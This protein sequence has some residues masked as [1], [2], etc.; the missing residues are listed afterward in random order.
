MSETAGPLIVFDVETQKLF[1]EVGGPR[2]AG[3]LGLS[4]AV[5]YDVDTGAFH[6]FTEQN[7]GELI[8]QLFAARLVVGYNTL[9]FDYAVLKAYTDR[10]FNRVPSL[11]IFDHVYRRTNYRSRLDT[12]AFETLGVGKSG[13]GREAIVMWREG[14]VEELLAYCRDDV[15][16]TYELYQYGKEHG[17]VFTRDPRGRRTRVPIMW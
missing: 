11:D 15:R 5:S 16:L 9:K 14:R 12:I 8:D 13:D 10:R 17:A 7:V 1:E 4:V 6:D 3:K 2:N